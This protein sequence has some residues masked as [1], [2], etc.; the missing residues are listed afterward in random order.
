M[1]RF[2]I[3]SLSVFL[4]LS[5]QVAAGQIELLHYWSQPGEQRAL[6]D[7]KNRMTDNGH[8]WRDTLVVA[9]RG[10]AFKQELQRRVLAGHPPTMAPVQGLDI[11]R[12]A[13]LGFLRTLNTAAR[14]QGWDSHLP[15]VIAET[16]QYNGEFVALPLK[17]HRTNWMWVNQRVLDRIGAK[18]PNTWEEF[19]RLADRLRKNGYA[20]VS[21][22]HE[23]WQYALLFENV[24][25]SIGGPD[26]YRAALI[27]HDFSKMT[28]D[29]MARVFER[30]YK[31]LSY[32]VVDTTE[33]QWDAASLRMVD[34][35]AA[36][37]FMG[38]WITGEWQIR[39]K[40]PSVDYQCMTVPGTQGA[41]LFDIDSLAVFLQRQAGPADQAAQLE[42]VNLIMDQRF[43]TLL[44]R[45]QGSIPARMDMT[46]VGYDTCAIGAMNDFLEAD[47]SGA[48]LPSI[49]TGMA[50]TGSVQAQF[51]EQLL[52]LSEHPQS[53]E[54]SA[55]SLAKR[56]RYGLYLIR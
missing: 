8:R 4:G 36:F 6:S 30:Y 10:G 9:Q 52:Q 46:M 3:A 26:F 41:Y 27:E 32:A 25:L 11:Q 7:L 5:A 33:T 2:V 45:S 43:Q 40:R 16:L 38:D 31:I 53:Y 23:A 39:D 13:R 54:D 22:G 48:L 34:G 19:D 15:A 12:W 17:V 21:L 29:T 56:I 14:E 37:Q 47:T 44:N 18:P 55:E 51:F 35:Q 49:A 28:S 1:N 50:T 20:V 24:V 42:L